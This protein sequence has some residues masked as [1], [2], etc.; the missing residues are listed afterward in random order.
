MTSQTGSRQRLLPVSILLVLALVFAGLGIWQVKR[1]AW[2]EALIA[3]VTRAVHAAPVSI[4]A[5]PAGAIDRL[6][7][8]RVAIT[9]QFLPV[10]T[11]LATATSTLGNGYWVMVPLATPGQAPVWINRGF[12]P[13]G[14]RLDTARRAVPVTPVSIIGLIRPSEPK[15][16]FLR[17]NR[18]EAE[19]WYARDL[20]VM[21]MRRGVVAEP[22]YFLDAQ[23]ET[24][25]PTAQPVPVPGLTVI[26]FPNN[27][28]SYALTW[29]ALCALSLGA[30]IM[31]WRKAR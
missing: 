13:M 11:V 8:H 7:Y 15:G 22:R 17:A 9:G 1:L 29:F 28:L 20:P 24:P 27:H 21:N 6:A 31:V 16:T 25:R 19:R 23:V 3:D 14:T 2:K 10:A 12:V 18:P 30:A 4:A 26:A 5:V